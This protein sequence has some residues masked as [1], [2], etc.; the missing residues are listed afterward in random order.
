VEAAVDAVAAAIR[1]AEAWR[2]PWQV[3][4]AVADVLPYPDRQTAADA[5]ARL[6]NES[7]RRVLP[8]APPGPV[9]AGPVLWTRDRY[10]SRFAVTAPIA[11]KDRPQRWYLWDIDACGHEAFTVHSGF[12][13]T[14]E[15]E[16][17]Y[18]ARV[19]E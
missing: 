15:V 7:G 16:P 13:A 1:Q 14:A 10:G 19:L 4:T 11:A 17:S 18:L 6:R 2:A 12:Y 5:I 3:L 9:V 8:A